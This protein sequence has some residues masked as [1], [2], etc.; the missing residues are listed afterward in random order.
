[1]SDG[2]FFVSAH[3]FVEGRIPAVEVFLVHFV[4]G[5][6]ESIAKALVVDDLP[7]PQEA[8]GIAYVGIVDQAQQ[9]VVRDACLLLRCQI[10]V[11]IGKDVALYADILG[12]KGN[13]CG[14]HGIDPRGVIHKVGVKSGFLD[15]LRRQIPCQLIQDRGDHLNVSQFLRAY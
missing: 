1:M 10:L 13:A 11:Q 7:L 4:L 14:G 3:L 12:I 9:I 6:A 5:D 2:S 8:N 15:L